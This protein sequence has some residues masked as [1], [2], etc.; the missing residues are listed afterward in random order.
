MFWLCRG[1]AGGPR[2]AKKVATAV[3]KRDQE[4]WSLHCQFSVFDPRRIDLR[5]CEVK[6]FFGATRL[7]TGFLARKRQLHPYM[8]LVVLVNYLCGGSFASLSVNCPRSGG[9]PKRRKKLKKRSNA[10]FLVISS[11]DAFSLL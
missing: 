8:L 10:R 4:F 6:P 9:Y 7:D 3:L 1:G 2:F 5:S 11:C